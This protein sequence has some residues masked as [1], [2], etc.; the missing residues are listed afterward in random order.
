MK[1]P[2]GMRDFYA[3]RMEDYL[4]LDRTDRIPLLEQAGKEVIFLRPRRF[5]KS[6][7]LSMLENYYSVTKAADFERLFGGLAIGRNPTPLHNQYL[8]MKW[9]FS[10]IRSQGSVQIIEQ[11]FYNYLNERIRNFA[12]NHRH[13]LPVEILL[14]PT[15]AMA[16]FQSLL[17]AVQ[18]TPYQLYLFID[19]YDNFANEVMMAYGNESQE[20]Y[21][22]LVSGEGLLKTV[23]KNIK[24]AGA[25]EGLARLFITG[26]SPI[27][28]SDV[29][30]G[31]NV[32][33]NIYW[34][35]E[36]NDLCG[37]REDE[38]KTLV[39]RVVEHCQLPAEK[40][41]EALELMRIFYDGSR[42]AAEDEPLVYNPTQVFYFLKYFQQRCRY[43]DKMLDGNMAPDY[44]KLVY[45]SQHPDGERLLLDAIND[46]T[47]L[48]VE[49]VGERFGMR[50]MLA[51]TKRRE[52]LAALL[53]YLGVLTLAG[54]THKGESI[55]KI[56]NLVIR[57]LY[58]ERLLEMA[59]PNPHDQDVGVEAARLL[60]QEG[61]MQ[62]VCDFVERSYFRVFD[63]R[64]YHGA[65]ELTIKTAFLTLLYNDAF[66]IMDSEKALQRTYADL[67]M[68]LRP[69]MRRYQLLD[70]LIEFKYVA[71][72]E[73]TLRGRRLQEAPAAEL[74]AL[75][76]VKE[77]LAAAEK[78]LQDY[79]RKLQAKYG[80]DLRLR[81]YA[82]TAIGFER[83]VWR[84]VK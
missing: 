39:T 1:F 60:Y 55:L 26:V 29:T 31:H 73:V 22:A 3:L 13:L 38:V 35:P 44:Q 84:E 75:P 19:E 37:F 62:P 11:A 59:L 9:D 42:F 71:L 23:F 49:E 61:A 69:E 54:K 83:L 67:I 16:S 4:Y 76:K 32:S 78:Q 24:G 50:E 77:Q 66:Y 28:L 8:V 17:T 63:N 30:S 7:L 21:D 80:A 40:G 53:C 72:T 27:V 51:E 57:R 82:V 56:P 74:A 25:G 14:N 48:A 64:D 58:A 34:F 5:G 68:I 33:E 52:R 43:P 47:V 65:N 81:T 15:D 41:E 20:R 70:I 45:I 6:L 46:E 10:A 12:I 2:Y 79:R 18:Q 36:F